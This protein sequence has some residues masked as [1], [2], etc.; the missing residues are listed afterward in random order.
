MKFHKKKYLNTI[1]IKMKNLY[2]FHL[3]TFFYSKELEL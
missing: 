3:K 2:K 1:K